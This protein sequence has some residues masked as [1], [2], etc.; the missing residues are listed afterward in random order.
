MTT[1]AELYA[2]LYVRELPAQGLLRLRP[3]L[4]DK[5]FVVMEGEPPM[6]YVCSLNAK[7]RGLGVAYGMTTVEIET[8]ASIETIARSLKEEATTRAA[9]LECA[10]MF[11]PR[12]EDWS[13]AKS[14]V[15]VVD[16]A[17]TEKL[18][19]A[20]R[21]LGQ[22]LLRHVRDLGITAS[23]TVC[24]NVHASMCLARG[25]HRSAVTIIEPGQEVAALA[26]LPLDVLDLSADHAETFVNWGIH[27][28]GMLALLPEKEL[29]ARMGQD[30]KR[31]RKLARGERTQLF[32]PHEQAFLLEERMELDTPV[33][34]LDSLLFVIGMMLQQL[35]IRA[36]ARVLA[37][38]SVTIA[39]ALEGGSSHTRSV[40]P[41]LP[42]ND[43][44]LWL[45]LLHLE[46]EAH[47]PPAA[48]LS[49]SLSADPGSTSKLQLGLFSPQL[50]EPMR[51][52][53]TL[54]RIRAIVGEDNVGS[55]VLRDTHQ[56]DSFGIEP[57]RVTD[58]HSSSASLSF[59]SSAM[60]ILRPAEIVFVTIYG[61]RPVTFT[62][63]HKGYEVEHSYGPWAASGAWWNCDHWD[64]EQWDIV[65]RS[66]DEVLLYG[67]MM[68]EPGQST[69]MMMALYD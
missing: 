40:R 39:L 30:G 19:G 47:L 26:S 32:V 33:E 16:I 12:I 60:R 59:T 55:P 6:Q 5:P 17:G 54:A 2:C 9:L 66:K 28:L 23:L 38:A 69:W 67:C 46:L 48:I 29:I 18:L 53:V 62:F 35:I 43:R 58:K 49:L 61:Q 42:T 56:A 11:S 44:Q 10:G 25:S 51:L 36:A 57:F 8:F 37:L 21:M 31:L 34:Q 65:A 68:R 13:T 22:N 14:F 24:T 45:K 20:P 64:L 41:A 52:D 50:P 15:C 7:A 3:E 27:T 4:R 1:G 63:R